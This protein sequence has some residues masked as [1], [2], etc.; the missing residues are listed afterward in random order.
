VWSVDETNTERAA[1]DETVG[2]LALP[3]VARAAGATV[4]ATEIRDSDT[5][6]PVTVSRPGVGPIA[7]GIA[8]WAV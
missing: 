5:D 4:A 1:T 8:R 3:T 6:S 2:A 7:A